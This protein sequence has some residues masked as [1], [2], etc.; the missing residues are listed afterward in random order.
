MAGGNRNGK[1][2]RLV[3]LIEAA[4]GAIP[5]PIR[6]A[7]PKAELINQ[8]V[9]KPSRV[10]VRNASI[11]YHRMNTKYRRGKKHGDQFTNIEIVDT[12]AEPGHADPTQI[13]DGIADHFHELRRRLGTE[14]LCIFMLA[15]VLEMSPKQIRRIM[16]LDPESLLS[17]SIADVANAEV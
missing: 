15:R 17:H 13:K 4:W 11:D 8:V 6:L 3:R 12:S 9:K 16:D 5:K 10:H 2:I 7:Y 1:G 14:G